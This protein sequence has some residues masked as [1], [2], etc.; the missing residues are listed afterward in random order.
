[1]KR[2]GMQNL[3]R[4]MGFMGEVGVG[5]GLGG[6]GEGGERGGGDSR[7]G[8]FAGACRHGRRLVTGRCVS[9]RKTTSRSSAA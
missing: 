8:R 7:G 5:R 3:V 9:V 2:R 6:E 1:M 4:V